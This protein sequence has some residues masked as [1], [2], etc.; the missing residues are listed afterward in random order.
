LLGCNK[1]EVEWE[2][3]N[4]N[5]DTILVLVTPGTDALGDVIT[6]DLT[7]VIDRDNTLGTATVDPASGPVGTEHD[8]TVEVSEDFE[9]LVQRVTVKVS[10]EG[11]GAEEW[12][13]QR[14]PAFIGTWGITVQSLGGPDEKD[15]DD[16]FNV[17]LWSPVEE[18]GAGDE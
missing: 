17:R 12:E 5:G 1:D 13:L 14:D 3:V 4:G 9:E 7:P 2:R 10:A 6:I 11:R 8:L 15:R 18:P 16:E